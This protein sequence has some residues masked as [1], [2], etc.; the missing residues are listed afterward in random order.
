MMNLQKKLIQLSEYKCSFKYVDS[1]FLV[2]MT[3]PENWSI[4]P[5]EDR[6]VEVAE[7]D[8]VTFYAA[9]I[10]TDIEVAFNL[11]DDTI[12]YNLDVE[13]KMALL[14][15]NIGKLQELFAEKDLSELETI[16]FVFKT[17]KE[18]NVTKKVTKKTTRKPYTRKKKEEIALDIIKITDNN[19]AKEITDL[20]NSNITK[21]NWDDTICY[22]DN[23][24]NG[25]AHNDTDLVLSEG[26]EIPI[27]VSEN[28]Y[29]E[30]VE[31]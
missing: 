3:Y 9:P 19:D 24:D 18:K 12:A 14:K 5:S 16:E 27:A 20:I 7:E 21:S 8:G 23:T 31:R 26:A 15:Y 10:E 2:S 28:K 17:P 13:K 25:N 1:Y 4:I 22:L 29:L 6:S 11:I 30:E